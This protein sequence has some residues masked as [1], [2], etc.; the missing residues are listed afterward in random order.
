[1]LDH[2]N[3]LLHVRF[4]ILDGVNTVINLYQPISVN[5]HWFILQHESS[6][7]PVRQSFRPI[8]SLYTLN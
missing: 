3:G 8:I 5:P 6:H 2:H 4:R 1:M 7:L